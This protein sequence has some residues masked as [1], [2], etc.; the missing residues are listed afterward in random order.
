MKDIPL[1]LLF[2]SLLLFVLVLIITPVGGW[3]E[4]N[5]HHEDFKFAFLAST[6]MSFGSLILVFATNK[7]KAN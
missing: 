7:S 6:L 2:I 1:K 5:P 4:S 3:C